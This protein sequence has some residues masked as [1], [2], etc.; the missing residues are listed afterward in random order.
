[1]VIRI[2]ALETSSSKLRI[3]CAQGSSRGGGRGAKLCHAGLKLAKSG[4]W[5]LVNVEAIPL[6][7]LTN[8]LP[9]ITKSYAP[10]LMHRSVGRA[11]AT[12][13]CR[14]YEAERLHAPVLVQSAAL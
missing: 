8:A 10:A 13:E 11:L 1:M 4:A 6:D 3:V 7:P 2:D 9:G 5:D 14:S 12:V